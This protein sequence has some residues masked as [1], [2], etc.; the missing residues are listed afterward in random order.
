MPRTPDSFPGERIEES[1][2]LED[3]CGTLPISSGE[4]FY[5]TNTPSGSGFFFN[6]SGKVRKLGLDLSAHEQLNT[7]SHNVFST[8]D[9]IEYCV[10]GIKTMRSWS[11]FNKT[12]LLQQVNIKYDSTGLISSVTSS[13]GT[14]MLYETPTY[15][16]KKQIVSISR[17]ISQ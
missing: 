7:I 12:N 3:A 13:V 16:N 15:N 2:K 1:I 6:E 9:D 10:Y 11:D 17:E 14:L 8:I 4:V 5:S